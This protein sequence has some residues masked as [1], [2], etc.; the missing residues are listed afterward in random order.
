MSIRGCI[1]RPTSDLTAQNLTAG[2]TVM[3]LGTEIFDSDTIHD[4]VTNNSRFTIPAGLNGKFGIFTACVLM[5]NV[6]QG[7]SNIYCYTRLR[8]NGTTQNFIDQV[9][10]L[11][12]TDGDG[13]Q[14][15]YVSSPPVQLVTNDFW[16]FIVQNQ[17]DIAPDTSVDITAARTNFSLLVLG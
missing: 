5:V 9:T 11:S 10:T 8:Q 6:S 4:T 14:P 1:A 15:T 17:A 3:P 16:E 7:A 13:P 2:T 12:G